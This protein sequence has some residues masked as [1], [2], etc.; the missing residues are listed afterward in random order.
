[1]KYESMTIA[2]LRHEA[3]ERGVEVP[4]NPKK[5]DL[6]DALTAADRAVAE[7]GAVSVEA[8]LIEDSGEEL[9]VRMV[10]G[11]LDANFGV[12]EANVDR[13][14]ADYEGWEPSADSSDDVE[15]CARTR[16]YLNGL[17]GEIDERR[18]AVKREYTKPLV[19]FEARANHVR[20]RIKEV[21]DRLQDVEKRADEARRL[22]K[23]LEL[24]DEYREI[25]P[26]LF[27]VVPYDRIA[28]P[29]WLNKKPGVETCKRELAERVAKV[30]ADLEVLRGL[31]LPFADQ[32]EMRFFDTLDLGQAT[33]WSAKLVADKEKLDRLKEEQAAMRAEPAPDLVPV[34]AVKAVPEPMPMIV[35]DAVPEPMPLIESKANPEPMPM[36]PAPS[37]EPIIAPDPSEER[38]PWVVV[39]PEA[40]RSDMQGLA[41]LLKMSDVSGSIHA[42]TLDQVYR[43]VYG[44]R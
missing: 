14:L 9:A 22:K 39:V 11:V 29:K 25:A 6:V 24:V 44:G 4:R 8:E 34:A 2:Q 32:A 36:I 21:S 20:D 40:T 23:R 33:A 38:G 15:Q 19:E 17:A 18:K 10:P 43:K 27:P 5:G 31:D 37:Q 13:I 42:G 41:K 1:M 3:K 16:K 12:L 28:D 7:D 35:S 26:V 30:A